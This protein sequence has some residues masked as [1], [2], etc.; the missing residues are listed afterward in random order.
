MTDNME[1]LQNLIKVAVD[2]EYIEKL[3]TEDQIYIKADEMRAGL[4]ALYPVTDEEYASLRKRLP[5]I[6]VHSIGYA[7]TLTKR[8][9]KHQE[10]W[11]A[12][13]DIDNYFWNRYKVYLGQK[14][15]QEI[16]RRLDDT[17]NGIMDNLGDPQSLEPFQR[18]GL[19]LGDVQSGKTSTYI[20]ICNKAADVGYRI[21]IVLAGMMENL[22]IQT[23]ERLDSDFVGLDSKYSL[24]R[25]ADTSKKNIKVG[26]G[27]ISPFDEMK[28][29]TRFTSVTH[30]FKASIL[31][32]LGLNLNDLRGTALFVVK[33]NKSILNNL[34]KWLTKDEDIL[35]LPMLL[36]DDEADNASVNTNDPEKDPTAIN[37]AINKILRSFKQASYLGITATP[38]ANIF[39]DP[40]ISE[41][42]AAKDLF[43]KDFLT[44]L[45]IP[46]NYIGADKIFGSDEEEGGCAPYAGAIIPILNKE[47]EFYYPF[48]HKKELAGWLTSIP[49]SLKEAIRYFILVTAISDL[50]FD[51]K[52]H[53][54][55][56][57]NVS[58]FTDV[59]IKTQ[60][61]IEDYLSQIKSDIINYALLPLE[62]SEQIVTIRDLH[63]TWNKFGLEQIS[64][65]RWEVILK[66]YLIR[67]SRRIEVRSVNQKTG[68]KSL[69]YYN[70]AD[71]GMRVIA[72]GGN[73]LSRGLTLEGLIVTYFYRNT[74]MYD[75]LLQMGRWFGYR[76]NYDDIF[77]LW[78]GEEA[79]DWYGYI[80]NAVNEL[81]ADLR[82]MALQKASPE[83]FGL[84]V[85]QDPGYLIVTARNKMRTGTRVS[86]PISV[87]GRMIETPRLIYSPQILAKNNDLCFKA[88]ENIEKQFGIRHEYD[89]NVRAEIWR[90]VPR[91]A[92]LDLVREYK[93]HPWN[94]NFQP[95]ALAEYIKNESTLE[96]WDVGIPFGKDKDTAHIFELSI[97][98][99]RISIIAEERQLIKGNEVD[100]M[101]RV[102]GTHVRIGA[103]GCT[104][105]GLDS[106][107]I[108][109][110]KKELNTN[111]KVTDQTYLD[112]EL[113]RRP[114]ALIHIM[115]NSRSVETPELPEYIC[116][117]G[118]GF[119]GGANEETVTYVVNMKELENYIDINE[120]EDNDEIL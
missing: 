48:K 81:K 64:G 47:Q 105:I 7:D 44:L 69:D 22:R 39:I 27:K 97:N 4:E 43:P 118:L 53:R 59:Q 68:S 19:L 72:V 75:T 98:G 16:I 42:G 32:A 77:K 83:Q 74:M 5:S 108:E 28:H 96:Y 73:S 18:R 95:V 100:Q 71:V 78:L 40:S 113:K 86:V 45:P 2:S 88:I 34:Q 31:S 6:I 109:Y 99:K 61:L 50:R 119:P 55:M 52:E 56:M 87:S 49:P 79:V 13:R 102:N 26:V 80:T 106:G 14:R 35:N 1:I 103:G 63:K 10:G 57:V 23:Q 115:H 114:I 92:I 62:A 84:K 20:G 94:L 101:L 9:G 51:I 93:C 85:R 110:A 112:K 58:R 46:D 11:Y 33:K 65:V 41:D 76:P 70:Y 89:E 12:N 54:T 3:P 90:N 111:G 82:I 91:E 60:E 30:D 36:I 15:S 25:K 21:I 24:D 67:S 104:K 117:L 38:F 8:D 29:I 120:A 66:E 116:G 17:T 107:Q 37:A